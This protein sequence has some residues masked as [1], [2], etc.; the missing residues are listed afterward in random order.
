MDFSKFAKEVSL[1]I[2]TTS[3]VSV[4]STEKVSI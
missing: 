2:E 3:K 4:I 1:R